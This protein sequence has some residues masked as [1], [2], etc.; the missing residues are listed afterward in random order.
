M[1]PFKK[2]C[3]VPL[4]ETIKNFLSR[5]GFERNVNYGDN[6]MYQRAQC[7][8]FMMDKFEKTSMMQ[9]NLISLQNQE[10]MG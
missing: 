5:Q 9:I 7:V 8:M 3:Y 2:Y 10:N 6:E 4:I 1:I